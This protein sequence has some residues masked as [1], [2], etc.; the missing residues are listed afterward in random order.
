MA[1]LADCLVEIWRSIADD[2][3]GFALYFV[4]A[5]CKVANDIPVPVSM[6]TNKQR[7]HRS[8][9]LGPIIDVSGE[10]SNGPACL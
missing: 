7:D 10:A 2:A 1:A 3:D 9:Q 6:P 5:A 4:S 8:V